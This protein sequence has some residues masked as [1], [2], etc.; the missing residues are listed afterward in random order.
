MA[1]AERERIEADF[2]HDR[3]AVI[4]ATTAFGMGVDKPNVRWVLHHDVADSIDSYWQEVGRAG[5][6]GEPADGVLLYRSQDLGVRRFF[7][8]AGKIH[9]DQIEQVVRA[10]PASG[11]GGA[12]RAQARDRPL[13]LEA[14][15]RGQSPRGGRGGRGAGRRGGGGHARRGPHRRGGGR[16][17]G[18]GAPSVLRPLARRDDA[19]VRRAPRRVPA[20]VH[21]L[22]LRG[23]PRGAVPELA[24]CA[25][26][27]G[28]PRPRPRSR[29]PSARGSPTRSGGR[30]TSSVTRGTPWSCCSR[31]W[32][33]GRCRS[34][35]SAVA[36]CSLG[37]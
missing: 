20:R 15:R 22:L 35:W 7:A 33:T 4:V 28:A 29:S 11:R 1:A 21:P 6:D 8:G 12:A 16:R 37:P 24:T 19:R 2:K 30:A 14:C 32:A 3:V 36:A 26:R 34:S 18:A 25:T 10:G 23:G 9:D 31:A 5:R 27:A 17:G 13:G